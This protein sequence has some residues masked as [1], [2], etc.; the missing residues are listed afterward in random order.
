MSFPIPL[1]FAFLGFFIWGL[2]RALAGKWWGW[3]VTGVFGALTVWQVIQIFGWNIP[4]PIMVAAVG[5]FAYALNQ[6]F[7]G[8][9]WGWLILVGSA[10][11][12]VWQ[13]LVIFT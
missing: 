2:N 11:V 12:I 7:A 8:K 3:I 4:L 5:F 10:L 6:I 13:L 1:V 9:W